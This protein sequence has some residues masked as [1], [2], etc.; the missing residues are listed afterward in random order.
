MSP[1][2]VNRSSRSAVAIVPPEPIWEPI[3][4]VRKKHDKQLVRWMPHISLL[5]PFVPLDRLDDERERLAAAVAV[6]AAP[7]QPPRQVTLG[8]F[9]HFRHAS[10][11]ATVWIDP[12][13]AEPLRALYVAL[14][15][16]YPHLDTSH[17]F[18]AGFTPHL[19]VGQTRTLVLGRRLADELN[20]TWQPLT[21][22][23]DA[24][25]VLRRTVNGPFEV[26][27]RVPL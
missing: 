26:A 15:A 3:N 25:T 22:P 21:F 18:E 13:P 2:G 9:R 8:P 5:F 24:L 12:Q 4:A 7:G 16:Q 17:R 14:A 10:N 23:L 27:Y 11:R 19:S 1:L 20:E 6:V